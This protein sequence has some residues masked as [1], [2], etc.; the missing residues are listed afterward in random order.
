MRWAFVLLRTIVWMKPPTCRGSGHVSLLQVKE[1]LDF[2]LDLPNL[3][4]LMMGKLYDTWSPQSMFYM[5]DFAAKLVRRFPEKDVLHI[6]CP[7]NAP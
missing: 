2:L 1:P 6:S 3:R 4:S 5:M 7:E